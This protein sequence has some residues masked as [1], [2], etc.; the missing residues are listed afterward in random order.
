MNAITP[1]ILAQ[2]AHLA[3]TPPVKLVE[4]PPDPNAPAIERSLAAVPH[5]SAA[6]AQ[7]AGQALL[8]SGL[9]LEVVR[10]HLAAE[11]YPNFGVEQRTPDEI[12][13]AAVADHLAPVA[14]PDDYRGAVG[15]QFNNRAA[16]VAP[17]QVEALDE[18]ACEWAANAKV[19]RAVAAEVVEQSID[20]ARQND[21]LS[22]PDATARQLR[23]EEKLAYFAGRRGVTPETMI[24]KAKAVL[25]KGGKFS[26]RL[27]A[28]GALGNAFI[29]CELADHFDRLEAATKLRGRP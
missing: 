25:A 2:A 12:E 14:K 27:S 3:D 19:P 20:W 28:V 8:N 21:A 9:P 4:V 23:H 7:A 6:S 11:G 13:R 24:E 5:L 15:Y 16:G 17:E 29:I 18:M 26:E 1:E 10:Q 22:E